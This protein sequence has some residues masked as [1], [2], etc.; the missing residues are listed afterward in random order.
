MVRTWKTGLLFF[1]LALSMGCQKTAEPPEKIAEVKIPQG[2]LIETEE[3]ASLLGQPDVVIVDARA[4]EKYKSSHIPRAV[5][6][7]KARFR[8]PEDI[9]YKNASG[10][11]IP[12]EKAEKVFGEAGIGPDSRV[13]VYDS[14]TF[15]DAS[16]VWA[17]LK[18]YGHEKV[19]VL[20]GGYEKWFLEGRPDTDKPPVV[21]KATFQA[22]PKPEM[23]A[24]LDWILQNEERITLLDMRSFAEYIGTN[25]AGN[26][27]GGS[28]PGAIHIEWKELAG[29]STV[30][31]AEELQKILSM[32]GVTKDKEIVTYC[33]WGI[34]RST[35]GFMLVKMLGFEKVRVFGGSMED[36]AA[37]PELPIGNAT[38]IPANL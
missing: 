7:P 29:D 10:F 32:Y 6:I 5:N 21:R 27:R 12:T 34:G 24:T 20:K 9:Q 30:K 36:W 14:V 16:I 11:A 35:Y 37:R 13:V 4:E 3:L 26:K 17:L 23:T 22:I 1:L 33:N 8:T 38:N 19:Q 25:P 28:I 15:P 31:S 18:Y 2:Y